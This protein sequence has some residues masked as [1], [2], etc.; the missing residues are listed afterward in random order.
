MSKLAI[1]GG[2]K[3]VQIDPG[4]IFSWPI[5]TEEDE[6]A[7]LQVLRAGKMSQTDITQKYHPEVRG[8]VRPVAWDEVC[9]RA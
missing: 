2:P 8:G 6:E 9:A 7:A 3:A 1:N 4:D 5:I